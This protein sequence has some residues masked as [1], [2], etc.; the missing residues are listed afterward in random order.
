MPDYASFTALRF[1]TGM[2]GMAMIQ[3]NN[4]WGESS[5]TTR[6][7]TFCSE[8]EINVPSASQH[9]TRVHGA[10]RAHHVHFRTVPVPNQ[11]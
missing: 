10:L 4:L 11:W 5:G 2:G 9:R 1:L 8:K 3:T 6:S 7:I